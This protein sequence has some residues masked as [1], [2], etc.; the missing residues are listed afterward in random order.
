[1]GFANFVNA[2]NNISFLPVTGTLGEEA[3]VECIKQGVNDYVLKDHLSRLPAAL[4]QALAEKAL[5]EKNE[6]AHE[7]LRLSEARNRD[8]V[9][10][11]IFGILRV[12]ADGRFQDANPA[13]LRMLGCADAAELRSLNLA[14][15]V[16]RFLEQHAQ[17]MAAC[18]QPGQVHAAETEWRR[19]DGG[20][21]AV[22]LHL[23]R[24]PAAGDSG[25]LEVIAEDVTEVRA[26]E[27]QLREAQKFEAIG[28][29]AGGVAHDFN[30]A[31]GAI[32]G[33]AE[34]GFEQNCEHPQVAERFAA[35]GSRRSA[36]L[37]R[38]VS[39]SHFRGARCFTPARSTSTA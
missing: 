20:I 21:L 8:L 3:A 27:R 35:F 23:R 17:L 18:R 4:T 16:F 22:R 33:G 9:E 24:L 26:M 36:P 25:A 6:Q 15:D 19:R 34:L 13:L 30:N 32:L 31:V 7:A 10:N 14:N 12:S 11:S 29:L 28:Q 37:R 5:R 39:C 38:R 1:M 2:G